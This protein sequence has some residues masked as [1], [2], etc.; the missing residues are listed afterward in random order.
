MGEYAPIRPG[1]LVVRYH[2][3]WRRRLTLAGAILGAIVI[4]YA[5]YEWGRFDGGY[6]VFAA[7]QER[8]NH[9]AEIKS[10][11]TDNAD[12][13]SRVTDAD[14]ARNVDRKSY[15]DVET[16]LHDLQAQVQ[17]QR[18][19]LAFY[20]GIVSPEDGVG[21]LRIQRLDILGGGAE[22]H[23][24]L[25]LVLMQSMRQDATVSGSFTVELEGVRDKQP[26]RLNLSDVGG[27][28]RESGDVPFSFRYFQSIEREL[29]LPE[30]FEPSA[31]NVEV[32][33]SRQQPLRQSFPWQVITTG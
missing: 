4:V 23:Y 26:A 24:K 2:A 19:E 31:I 3:P 7:A 27:Q 21:G 10:L 8:R 14:M 33:S 12:L 11:Q 16:T 5:T 13:R 20:R 9:A 1:Q 18:E 32:K 29:T 15:A 17:R 6:S 30:G 22:R 28:A 25:R